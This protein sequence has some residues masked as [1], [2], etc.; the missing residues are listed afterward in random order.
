[1]KIL[2][3][4]S[5][6]PTLNISSGTF[7]TDEIVAIPRASDWGK[8][9]PAKYLFY[10]RES[11]KIMWQARNF[12]AVVLCTV[13][14]EAFFAGKL[15][16]FICPHT[17]ILCA[18]L[19]MPRDSRL[20]RVASGWLKGINAFLCIRSG[21]IPILE[22]RFGIS[23]DRCRFTHFPANLPLADLKITEGDYVYS[24]GWAHRDWPTLI[25][26]LSMLPYRAILSVGVP[27]MIPEHAR[28]RITVLPMQTPE[29]GRKLMA[30]AKIVVLS[31]EDTEL[32]SGPLVLLDAM[33]AGKAVVATNVNGTR[34]Y[35]ED[36]ETG[37]L[38]V[39]AD[40]SAMAS[41]VDQL[42]KNDEL[43]FNIGQSAK[44]TVRDRFTIAQFICDIV[45][46]FKQA[47]LPY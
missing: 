9:G 8:T 26:A 2:C 14:V 43:R 38:V 13:G 36:G 42:M 4:I 40:A 28:N 21:D 34:D 33:A 27:V 35:V 16:R 15:G 29:A 1:M 24:G 41:S 23:P 19:L 12:D 37:L 3:S 25:M 11:L 6:N 18:D 7:G 32:P 47:S 20:V 46:T 10:L 5:Y 31:L 17:P 22:R 39:P 30:A 45:Q 44:K